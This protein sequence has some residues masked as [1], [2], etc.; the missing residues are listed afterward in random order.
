MN[1]SLVFQGSND[2]I[3]FEVFE[4]QTLFEFFLD[5]LN[6]TGKNYFF[7]NQLLSQI[8][9][10]KLARISECLSTVNPVLSVL[11]DQNFTIP[12]NYFEQKWLSS[13]HATWVTSQDVVVDIDKLRFSNDIE[14]AKIGKILHN[15]YPDE[16]RKIKLAEAC[17]KLDIID[18]YEDIN[19]MIHHIENA[20][21]TKNIEFSSPGRY[22]IIDN[23]YKDSIVTDNGHSNFSFAYTYLGRQ[24]Y[25]RF[26]T[27]ED[28]LELQDHFNFDKLE[29]TFNLNLQKSERIPFSPEF[30]SWCKERNVRPMG[31]CVPIANIVDL[32]KNLLEYRTILYKNIK[33]HNAASLRVK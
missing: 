1:F 13:T 26:T 3:P 33:Q 2:S 30:L 4:N 8:L 28:K 10:S 27:F 17:A 31:M 11:A 6:T 16:I 20:F 23:P 5:N 19:I 9:D 22:N 29:Y 7:T 14:T 25:D 12:A 21:E 24:M 18:Q 15:L 32:D